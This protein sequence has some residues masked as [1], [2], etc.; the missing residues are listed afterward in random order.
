MK[1]ITNYINEAIS[2]GRK[3]SVKKLADADGNYM[4]DMYTYYISGSYCTLEE[5]ATAGLEY[6]ED[7]RNN[8]E[9][10]DDEY[11]DMV[12]HYN[13]EFEEWAERHL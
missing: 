8:G 1:S 7:C 4:G 13:E 12:A 6:A 9:I 11:E 10:D 3:Y 2:T 5:W